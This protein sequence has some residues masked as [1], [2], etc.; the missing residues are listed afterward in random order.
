MKKKIKSFLSQLMILVM[1]LT[2]ANFPGFAE[3]AAQANHVMISQIYGAGGNSGAIYKRDF[4]ELYNPTDSAVDLTGWSIQYRSASGTGAPSQVSLTGSIVSKGYYL[5]AFKVGGSGNGVD[6][7]VIDAATESFE[8]SG[9]TGRVALVNSTAANAGPTSPGVIDYVGYGANAIDFEGS[10]APSP[11]STQSIVRAVEGV[12]TDNNGSDFK[13]AAPNPRSGIIAPATKCVAPMANMGN[14][15]VLAGTKVTFSADTEGSVV[16]YNTTSASAIE[17]TSGSSITLNEDTT[18]YVRAT[19]SGLEASDVVTYTYTVDKSDPLT[20]SQ[21]KAAAINT[22]NVKTQGVVTYVSGKNVYIQDASGAICLFL[23]ADAKTLKVGD[24]VVAMGTRVDYSNLIELTNVNEAGVKVLGTNK[25]PADRGTVTIEDL[26]KKPD[27]KTP[28][29]DHMCELVNIEGATL[30]STTQIAQSGQ[31]LTISPA[32]NLANYAGIAVNDIVNAKVRFYDASGT[33]KAEVMSL[34]KVGTD[35]KV[36]LTLSHPSADAVTGA[37]LTVTASEATAKIYYTLDGSDPSDAST[38][39]NGGIKLTGDLGQIITLKAIAYAT[40]KDASEVVTAQYKLVAPAEPKTIK[41]VLDIK[42]E[43]KDIEV[44]G[45]LTYFATSYNN[46]V[47]QAEI[48]GSV[49]SLYVFGA[50]PAGAK[51]GDE[52]KFKGTFTIY[53]G[54]PEM[55][56]ILSSSIIGKGNVPTV[57]EMTIADIKANGLKMLGKVVKIKNAT[58]GTYSASGSTPITDSTGSTNLYKAVAFPTQ[59]FEK[60]VVD[61]T[62]MI[63]CFNADVQIYTGT[64]EANG[65]NVYDV[66]NDTKGPVVSPKDSYLPAKLGQDYTISVGVEDNKGV[67]DVKVTYKIG[68]KTVSSQLMAYESVNREY[69]FTIPKAEIVALAEEIEFTVTAT[70]VSGLTTTSTAKKI[71]IDN[72]A[73]V[74][75]VLPARN[76]SSGDNKTPLIAVEIQNAYENPVVKLGLKKGTTVIVSDQLMTTVTAN[77]SYKYQT[78]TLSD[79]QYQATVTITRSDNQI[80]TVSWNFVIGTPSFKAYF[81]QLHGHTA[82]YSDGSGTLADGLNYLKNIPSADNVDFVSF[83]DH[84]NYFDTTAAANP[85]DA[86]ND[87]T[88]MTAASLEKWNTYVSDMTAFNASNA[89]S[90]LAFPGFEMTWSGGPGHINT[91]NSKGLVSRNNT[92]LNNKAGD[93]GLKAYYEAL[94]KNTDPLAN[95]SQFNHPGSTFGTFADFAYWTPAYDNKM[96]SVEVGNGEGAI[97]SGG[98][99]PSYTEYTKALDKGWHVAPTNNQDNHKGMWGNA[100]TARTVIITDDFSQ[101]GLLTGLKNMSV[102]ATEDKNL[103]INYTVNDLVMG[104]IIATVPTEPLKFVVNVDDP[105]S[106]DSIASVEIVTNGGKV[107]AKKTFQG[108]SL[109]WNFELP[110]IQGYYY[111]RVTQADKNIAVTAPVWVG[112]APLV[113]ISSLEC[114]TKM[115]VTGE[116]LTLNTTLFN[117]EASAVTLKNI[118]YAINGQNIKSDALEQSITSMGTYKNSLSYTPT[119]AGEAT[120]NVTAEILINGELKQFTQDIKINVRASENLVYVG[121][122]ASHYNE[123]VS[124]NYKDSMGNFADMAV[125]SDVRVVILN[126]S[127]A[128]IAATTNPKYKMIVLTPPTRRNGNDFLIGY[129]NYTDAEV[130]AIKAYSEAGNTLIITNW[131]DFYENYTKFTDGTAHTLDPMSHMAAQQNKLLDAIGSK[132]RVSDDEAKDDKTNG[133]QAQRLYL[134]DYNLDNPFLARVKPL[135]QV[136]SS[137]GGSTIYAIGSDKA[138]STTIPASVSPMVYTFTTSYSSDDD[139]SGTTHVSGVT[140]PKYNDRYMLAASETLSHSNGKTATVIVAGS[141]MMSNFEIKT[142]MDSYATPEYSNYTIL[143]NVIRFINPVTVTNISDVHVAKEGEQF[144]IIGIVTSN[145]SGYDKDTAFFDCIYVQ[146]TTGGINAFPVAGNV[147]KGQIVEITGKTSS[148][149]GERQIAVEKITILD[150]RIA[151]LPSAKTVTTKQASESKYLGSLVTVNGTI[152]KLNYS[153]NIIESILVKDSSGVACRVFIDGYITQAKSIANL[154]V[155][156][157]ITA[158]GLSSIDPDGARI[159]IR[160]RADVICSQPSRDDGNNSGG[161]T[162]TNNTQTTPKTPEVAVVKQEDAKAVVGTVTISE[163]VKKDGKTTAAVSHENVSKMLEQLKQVATDAGQKKVIELKVATTAEDK[164]VKV[165]I[166]KEAFNQMASAADANVKLTTGLASIEMNKNT[167]NAI[168]KSAQNA[169]VSIGVVKVDS[170]TL[171]EEVRSVVGNRPVFDFTVTAG[172]TKVSHF[173][174]GEVQVSMPYTLQPGESASALVVYYI[175]DS[176]KLSTVRGNYNPQTKAVVFKT[177]HFSTY[178]LG[179]NKVSFKDVSS[180]AWFGEAVNFVSSRQI[181]TGTAKDTF[182]PNESVTRAQFVVMLM[183]AYGIKADTSLKDNFMDAGNTYYTAYLATAKKM[184]IISGTGNNSFNPNAQLSRQD[185]CTMLYKALSVLNDLPNGSKVVSA[186]EYH[187]FSGVSSYAKDSVKAFVEQG[188]LS[189]SSRMLNPKQAATRA[190]LAQLLY[191]LLKM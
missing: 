19:K 180:T 140:V 170:Q 88:L 66:V 175:D 60:D 63:A 127:E 69:Q 145:A 14:G 73:Q 64:K 163:T 117:N 72:K 1:L 185:M 75:S 157:L 150:E 169:D 85:A 43:T 2:S 178:A 91:F 189:G 108:N 49:Y 24:E 3:E 152:T 5:I 79:G 173:G 96:V 174:D 56:S 165:V 25:T 186:S 29:Y 57:P 9:S 78:S 103:N 153:N 184:G 98:Y 111:V 76:S 31:T 86:L 30:A 155:G 22:A 59:V 146:D 171:S 164:D 113:G 158:T 177:S 81:G 23:T 156:N 151:A 190:E 100:N 7:P 51:I 138:P 38:L 77:T 129:K 136:Y 90:K 35:N 68:S 179:H 116:A 48:D 26:I 17:W 191:T 18:V 95:L 102:Y 107:A 120:V 147:K 97:G 15:A 55:K 188:Y 135:E 11:S 53:G 62:G 109:A 122:D 67:K 115:P 141:A 128:L 183:N 133:G 182:S 45:T 94:I 160:D 121:V 101:N 166:N 83:T 114:S 144:T 148:Y 44:K 176:G 36:R 149:N 16:E 187:D 40:G 154:A 27:G 159:R 34:T 134:K 168:Q 70:D 84:S 58:L 87:T 4:V 139:K 71:A 21:A 132:L 82:Q 47:I 167:L 137:Y 33:L 162:T 10:K 99:F 46:P 104:S 118:S 119:V 142:T 181:A 110:A 32:I 130:A 39:Y 6:L 80:T 89:G 37:T 41:E 20:I 93:A 106:N 161:S 65:F 8:L 143:E 74:V 92:A 28:G 54:L 126:T 52:V 12:D 42:T 124:G 105:D 13:N 50:A 172:T 123:Y 61:I 131:G 112:Q 125:G